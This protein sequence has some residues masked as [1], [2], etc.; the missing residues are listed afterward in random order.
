M[1]Y[2][3]NG[4]EY[5][6]FDINLFIAESGIIPVAINEDQDSALKAKSSSVLINDIINT[7]EYNPCNNPVDAW[8]IIESINDVLFGLVGEDGEDYLYC[9]YTRWEHVEEK[10]KCSK[11]IAACICFIELNDTGRSSESE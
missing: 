9:H 11:L 8:P 1:K 7:Y 6:E 5:S 2:T 10:Y 3:I 4:K